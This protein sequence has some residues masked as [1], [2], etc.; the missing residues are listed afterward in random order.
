MTLQNSAVWGLYPENYGEH[1]EQGLRT[2]RK[3]SFAQVRAHIR[4][5]IVLTAPPVSRI[6]RNGSI[7]RKTAGQ[8]VKGVLTAG[9]R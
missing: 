9:Q 5:L 1:G 2:A 4:V 3:R 6:A 8:K 7:S